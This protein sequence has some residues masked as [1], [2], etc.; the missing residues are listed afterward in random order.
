MIQRGGGVDWSNG[1]KINTTPVNGVD[2][3]A[4]VDRSG[5]ALATS[6]QL[7]SIENLMT[8]NTSQNALFTVAMS[9][10]KYPNHFPSGFT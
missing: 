5:Q 1:Q 8:M 2:S 7:W 9:T 10:P 6:G 3:A 4:T